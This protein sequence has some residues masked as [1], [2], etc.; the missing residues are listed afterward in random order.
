MTIALASAL[1]LPDGPTAVTPDWLTTVL[2]RCGAIHH[3]TVQFIQLELFDE[4]QKGVCSEIV[5]F[6]LTYDLPNENGPATLFGKFSHADPVARAAIHAIG[7]YQREIGFYQDLAGVSEGLVPTC[8]YSAIDP[9]TGRSTLLLE[10]LAHLRQVDFATG[11]NIQEAELVVHQLAHLHAN[12]WR[13]PHLQSLSWL[14][15]F[16]QDAAVRQAKFQSWWAVAPQRYATC[17]PDHPLPATFI[18]LGDR[19]SQQVA[20]IFTQL[21]EP[22]VTCVHADTHVLNLMFGTQAGDPPLKL[23]DWQA[24][25]LGCGM[26]DVAY[27]MATSIPVQQRRQTEQQLVQ[28]YHEQLSTYG[29]EGYCLEQ[30]WMDYRR[31]AFWPLSVIA[32]VTALLDMTSEQGRMLLKNYYQ[33]LI[34]FS[35]DHALAELL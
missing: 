6:R 32:S 28:H 8:Y 23:I 20:R 24:T 9:A 14:R 16:A 26:M 10:D 5:R 25:R 34:A 12:T 3:A 33:R 1:C 22:F 30:C 17:L 31:A 7:S 11:C 15:S 2:R 27:F 19:F 4:M 13:K 21:A 18:A 29:I 35:E